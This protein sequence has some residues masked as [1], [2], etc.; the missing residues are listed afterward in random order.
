METT[1]ISKSEKKEKL[2]NEGEI[3]S[4]ETNRNSGSFSFTIDI[5]EKE[6][7]ENNENFEMNKINLIETAHVVE[8]T[9]TALERAEVIIYLIFI[10]FI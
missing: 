8:G 7:V 2:E 3:T 1:T 5:N 10:D 6:N 4:I 9:E